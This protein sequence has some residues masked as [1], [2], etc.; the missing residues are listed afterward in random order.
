MSKRRVLFLAESLSVGG[1]EKALVSLLKSLDYSGLDVTLMLISRTGGFVKDVEDIEDLKIKHI[2]KPTV[3]P[4]QSFIN[5]LKIKAIY[6]WLP[7]SIVGDKL[8][9]GYDVV[10]AFC[11]G[12]LT[13]WVAS[14]T[15]PCRKIAWV[16]TDMALND[17]PLKTGVFHSQEEEVRAYNRFDEVVAVSR[18]A[19]E[20]MKDKFSCGRTQVIYNILD[21]DIQRKSSAF[22]TSCRRSKLNMVS[23]GRLEYV[24]GYDRLLDAM[25]VL[26]NRHHLDIHLS[27]VGDGSLRAELERKI[28]EYGLKD[29]VTLVGMQSNP[30]PYVAAS[31]LFVCPSRQEGF[32]IAILEAM[33]L[34]KPVVATDCA[35][36][37]EILG[38][39]EFG[40][41]VEN[42][43]QGLV[44]GIMQLYSSPSDVIRYSE[45]SGKRNAY[46]NSEAQLTSLYK[47]IEG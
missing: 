10:V 11:E 5:R 7:A 45:L 2:V 16:H 20:A 21:S 25:D 33:T 30:Y 9:K 4:L 34:G 14:A 37:S 12:Y 31:D 23:V 42:S 32:N 8:C 26:V 47:I 3:N 13:K 6:Q 17:W 43:M 36:P 27:L 19:E 1:A 22:A 46:Y 44:D 35:G 41:L 29:Y 24:K 28:N 40:L 18:L 38:G 39:G 15:V